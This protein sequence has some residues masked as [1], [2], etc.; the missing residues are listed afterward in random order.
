MSSKRC[1]WGPG[2]DV[3]AIVIILIVVVLFAN[4]C[5][6]C[7]RFGK[8]SSSNRIQPSK[9]MKVG[10]FIEDPLI[11]A[12]VSTAAFDTE[13]DKRLLYNFRKDG[14]VEVRWAFPGTNKLEGS[15]EFPYTAEGLKVRI[16]FGGR[17]LVY[18]Y[19]I[20][21][22]TLIMDGIKYVRTDMKYFVQPK[23]AGYEK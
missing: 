12:W 13:N 10:D 1:T 11:G 7:D 18:P 17:E 8:E 5:R 16:G 22:G 19:G 4:G 20:N 15:A 21:E 14:L 6:G 3:C 2:A 23:G 9:E